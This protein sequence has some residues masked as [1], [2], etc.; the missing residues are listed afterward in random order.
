[1]TEGLE[2]RNVEANEDKDDSIFLQFVKICQR[3]QEWCSG[4][5]L[6]S[7]LPVEGIVRLSL[8]TPSVRNL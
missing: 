1:M 8:L 4:C 2:Q 3:I 5:I 7:S 6:E